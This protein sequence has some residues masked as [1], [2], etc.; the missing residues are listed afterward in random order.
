[1]ELKAALK[2]AASRLWLWLQLEAEVMAKEAEKE[3]GSPAAPRGST[4]QPAPSGKSS[5]LRWAL[6]HPQRPGPAQPSPAPARGSSHSS[7][8]CPADSTPPS[9]ACV[10]CSE[11]SRAGAGEQLQAVGRGGVRWGGMGESPSGPEAA[12]RRPGGDFS[13][14]QNSAGARPEGR[15]LRAGQRPD[16]QT[17]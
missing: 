14:G 17:S 13:A 1:M 8:Q 3:K 5:R 9:S 15:Q 12:V 4:T 2:L 6:Q 7:P 11:P 10:P 16:S